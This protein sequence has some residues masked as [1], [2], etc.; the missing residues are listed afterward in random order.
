M[1]KTINRLDFIEELEDIVED[2]KNTKHRLPD[3]I[4]GWNISKKYNDGILKIFAMPS[5]KESYLEYFYTYNISNNE[6]TN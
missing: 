5:I 2:F 1:G 3:N 6:N 4:S